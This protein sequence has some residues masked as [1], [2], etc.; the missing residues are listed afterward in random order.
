LLKVILLAGSALCA[1]LAA[2]FWWLAATTPPGEGGG[3]AIV[4]DD[5]LSR[6]GS[7]ISLFRQLHKA[8][9]H[10]QRGALFA[11]AAAICQAAVSI[12]DMCQA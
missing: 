5:D 10:N 3:D 8:N 1:I 7:S 12:I 2:L 9:E 4:I 6:K 11:G